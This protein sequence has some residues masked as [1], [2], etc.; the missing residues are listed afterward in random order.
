MLR[1]TS[2]QMA[3]LQAARRGDIMLTSR[4]FEFDGNPVDD[5]TRERLDHLWMD[6]YL[7]ADIRNPDQP[8]VVELT[9]KGARALTHAEREAGR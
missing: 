7:D 2:Y 6:D 5:S 4:G 8:A 9:D 3:D 1:L